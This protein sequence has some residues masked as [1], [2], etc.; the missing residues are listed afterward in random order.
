M[1]CASDLV[2]FDREGRPE[3]VRYHLITPLLL[4]SIGHSS[5][6]LAKSSVLD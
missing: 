2:T 1:D 4:K 3:G 6:S 5:E